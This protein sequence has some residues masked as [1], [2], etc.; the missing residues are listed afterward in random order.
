MRDDHFLGEVLRENSDLAYEWLRARSAETRPEFWRYSQATE[1]AVGVLSVESRQRL[2]HELP[3]DRYS[4]GSLAARLVGE[5]LDLYRRLLDDQQLSGLH[6]APL[7]G[8]PDAAWLAKARLALEA[9]YSPGQVAEAVHDWPAGF[10]WMGNESD[11]WDK[12][13]ERFERLRSHPDERIQRVGK[14]GKECNAA[15]RDDALV[16]ERHRAVYGFQ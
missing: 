13:I 8:E 7:A 15:R 1:A 6:L 12:W 3:N 10:T 2:L 14:A 5:D 16:R 11:M 9:G 4:I